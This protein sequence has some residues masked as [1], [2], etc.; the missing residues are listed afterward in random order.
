M[1]FSTGSKIDNLTITEAI[2]DLLGPNHPLEFYKAT[3]DTDTDTQYLV[4]VS[5]AYA[6]ETLLGEFIKF[7]QAEASAPQATTLD[8]TGTAATQAAAMPWTA[9]CTTAQY[10]AQNGKFKWDDALRI[11]HSLV[12]RIEQWISL[13]PNSSTLLIDPNTV[14]IAG[15]SSPL[16][17][18]LIAPTGPVNPQWWYFTPI[19]TYSGTTDFTGTDTTTPQEQTLQAHAVY[20][21]SMLMTYMLQ[22]SA[23]WEFPQQ[24]PPSEAP[25]RLDA[26]IREKRPTLDLPARL[27]PVL[28][29]NFWVQPDRRQTLAQFKDT[30]SQLMTQ[31]GITPLDS[32]N[33]TSAEAGSESESDAETPDGDSLKKPDTTSRGEDYNT[34]PGNNCNQGPRCTV[35]IARVKGGG[36]S[37]VA[38]MDDL[39][40]QMT[41]NFIQIVQNPDLAKTFAITPPNGILLWGPPGNGKTFISRKLA[42]QSGL[43]FSLV[44]PSD[45]GSIY[46]H[47]TQGMIGELF[48]RA[49][50]IA[51]REKT[52]VL[53]CLEEFDTLVPNRANPT[54][55]NRSDEVAEFLTRLNNCADKGV[56]VIATTNRIDAIDPAVMR[57][58]RID[59]VVYVGLPDPKVRR[60][61]L[62]M[63]LDKRP[64]SNIDYTRL[65]DLTDGFTAGDISF[66]IKETARKSFE[67]S[68]QNP[69]HSIVEISQT[70]V[71]DTIK[72]N[73]PSITSA[74]RHSYEKLRD[75]YANHRNTTPRVG[76]KH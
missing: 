40:A 31:A 2:P 28:T 60:Q 62:E 26:I 38:G 69:D 1:T 37:E 12:C 57:K 43:Y 24:C 33:A 63:E 47:G 9:S 3:A 46:V 65:V 68:I 55:N 4:A 34:G 72:A 58:G 64:H 70:L 67:A 11:I 74:E 39:K 10:L 21:L 8:T 22:A 45:L 61:L 27:R 6:D 66:L 18:L 14:R 71:E 17:P 15:S 51:A 23:P 53:L 49:E 41:R 16:V 75:T 59:Q 32:T 44:N 36:F 7:S 25:E 48:S 42:E 56:Y 35:K 20:S 52:G 5:T 73:K 54:P 29:Q 50:K 13:N 76:F 19:E 30:L